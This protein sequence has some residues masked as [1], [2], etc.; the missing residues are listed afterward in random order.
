M[1]DSNAFLIV[2]QVSRYFLEAL[3]VKVIIQ[4]KCINKIMIIYS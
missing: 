3:H 4:N 2:I 1:N